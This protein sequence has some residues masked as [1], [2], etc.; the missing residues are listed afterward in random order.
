ME[1]LAGA[2]EG[3]DWQSKIRS[4]FKFLDS[5]PLH[6]ISTSLAVRE[7]SEVSVPQMN[8]PGPSQKTMEPSP[9]L[10]NKEIFGLFLMPF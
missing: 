4:S 2:L 7:W 3:E 9:M 5:C 10:S 6:A 8:E 1:Y